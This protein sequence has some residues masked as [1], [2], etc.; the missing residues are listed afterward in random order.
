MEYRSI[1]GVTVKKNYF[2]SNLYLKSKTY[3]QLKNIM[4]FDL[5]TNENTSPRRSR[6]IPINAL[7]VSSALNM[8]LLLNMLVNV[9]KESNSI[10]LSLNYI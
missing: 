4:I 5:E 3:I 2:K 6:A 7:L 1:S 9:S 8:A 10:K